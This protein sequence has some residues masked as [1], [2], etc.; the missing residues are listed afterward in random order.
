MK[1]KMFLCG[2]ALLV[3]MAPLAAT[4]EDGPAFLRKHETNSE[5]RQ[6]IEKLLATYTASVTN[7]DEA[8]FEALLIDDQVP[9]SSTDEIV[10]RGGDAQ[11]M[12]TRNYQRFRKSVFESGVRYTQ[13]FYNVHIDQ[14]GPLAQV[15]L[16]FVT[17]ETRSG[18]GG[19]G[20]KTLQ[21]VKVQGHWKIASEL[22]TARSL[23]GQP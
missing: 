11:A 10:G 22:Y 14:D 1:A 9:F 6:A 5:D 4:A 17:Q 7:S 2:M 23:P 16:D 12:V 13:H 15:S 19:Y 20:W 8:A 3:V 18:R 21:L